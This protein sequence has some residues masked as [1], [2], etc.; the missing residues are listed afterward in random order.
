MSKQKL[1]VAF[2]ICFISIMFSGVTTM[3]MSVYLPV[4]VRDLLGNVSDEKMHNVSAYINSFFLFGS[5][6]GGF[7]WGYICDKIGRA[8]AVTYSTAFYA[9]FTILTSF[10]DSWVLISTYRFLTGFGVGGVL[11]TTNILVCE[12]WPEHKRAVAIGIVSAAMPVGFIAAGA[13]N[14]LLSNWHSA[15]LVGIVPL[16]AAIV[17]AFTLA[18]SE[19]WKSGKQSNNAAQ[20]ASGIFSKDNSRNLLIGSLIFGTMLIGLWAVFS[21]A[22]TWVQSVTPDEKQAQQLRGTTMMLLAFSGLLGSVASGWI[23]NKLGQR[24]TLMM[25]FAMCFVMVFVVFK[26]NLSITA[27]T[28]AEM[29]VM[30]F[31]FGISQG[32]LAV[33]VPQLFPVAVRAFA[34]GFCYNIGRLFT[35]SVV[36][37]IGALVDF[38]GGYGNAIFIFSF[39]FLVGLVITGFAA[40]QRVSY[41]VM[42][43]QSNLN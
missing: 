4:A 21:W 3:L 38:L 1:T 10:S 40:W 23:T 28:F 20:T 35:A 30:A 22:P 9:L 7:T 16:A 5:M 37:F 42:K 19:G 13:M 34:T 43:Q 2:I 14:N 36:F 31:F 15:F 6:F 25:C 33:F 27:V 17:G 32:V 12:L 39:V 11:V 24:N 8:K 41:P 18:E 29:F 26:L